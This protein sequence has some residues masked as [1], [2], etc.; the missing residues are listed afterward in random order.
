[1]STSNPSISTAACRFGNSP[2]VIGALSNASGWTTGPIGFIWPGAYSRVRDRHPLRLRVA[3]LVN[4]RDH[5]GVTDGGRIQPDY[6]VEDKCLRIVHRDW[7]ALEL[8]AHG[9]RILVEPEWIE[10]FDLPLERERGL[11]E[12]DNH[13]RV[14]FALLDPTPG[15]WVGI[16]AEVVGKAGIPNGPHPGEQSLARSLDRHQARDRQLLK[17]AQSANPEFVEAPDWIRQ[18]LLAADAFLF[19]RPLADMPEGE[20]VIA[21]YPWFGDWGRDTMIALPGLALATGRP[22]SARRILE[23]FARFI[24]GGMLPNCFPDAGATAAYN[25]VDAALWY[26]GGMARLSRNN[27]G[28]TCH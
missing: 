25:S 13:L 6:H 5:H 22:A 14:G 27:R 12:R 8:L 3:L 15:D 10:G 4:A 9:G 23:T 19:A 21:G 28:H 20:S 7:F 17:Q 11:E 24:D 18:L 26:L 1:M 2:L 16:S